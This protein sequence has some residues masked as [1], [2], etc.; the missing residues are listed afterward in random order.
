MSG[1]EEA[2]EP[3][4]PELS[5][6]IRTMVREA[7]G[8]ADARSLAAAASIGRDRAFRSPEELFAIAV[9]TLFFAGG[10]WRH[11]AALATALA[12]RLPDARLGKASM[13]DGLRTTKDF[14]DA[15]APEIAAFV[16]KIRD[17]SDRG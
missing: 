6:V 3:I 17:P 14:A 10:D 8:D 7:M 1:V 2:W 12:A 9:P 11:P 16:R 4:L 13:S 5:P 15:F